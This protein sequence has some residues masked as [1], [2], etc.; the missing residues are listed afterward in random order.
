MRE[1][2]PGRTAGSWV[3]LP[4]W[5]PDNALHGFETDRLSCHSVP[6]LL[7]FDVA[8]SHCPVPLGLPIH[9]WLQGCPRR[10][11]MPSYHRA[12]AS[13]TMSAPKHQ[14]FFGP[15]SELWL[16]AIP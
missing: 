13:R 4:W 1:L 9:P 14:D 6:G 16:V 11:C 12:F 7:V 15:S 2:R 10:S 5:S 8:E 3:Q